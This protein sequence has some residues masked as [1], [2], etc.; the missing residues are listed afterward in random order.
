[1]E[2]LASKFDKIISQLTQDQ[3]NKLAL[4]LAKVVPMPDSEIDWRVGWGYLTVTDEIKIEIALKIS[5]A[6][7]SESILTCNQ[8]FKQLLN[9]PN[10]LNLS[11]LDEGIGKL[12][13]DTIP[14]YELGMVLPAIYLDEKTASLHFSLKA[15]AKSALKNVGNEKKKHLKTTQNQ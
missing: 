5:F 9:L 7:Q 4:E 3:Q 12:Y 6:Q 1:M 2:N 8:F 13:S 15:P 14:P 10:Q 11:K